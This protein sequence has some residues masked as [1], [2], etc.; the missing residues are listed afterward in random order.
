[1]GAGGAGVRNI[2]PDV[3]RYL[4]KQLDSLNLHG[5]AQVLR[6]LADQGDRMQKEAQDRNRNTQRGP[7]SIDPVY[8]SVDVETTGLIPGRHAVIE[9]AAMPVCED[10][11]SPKKYFDRLVMPFMGAEIDPKAMAIHQIP[12][13]MIEASQPPGRL[14]QDFAFWVSSLG[15]DET[16]KQK[17]FIGSNAAFDWSFVTWYFGRYGIENPFHYR[18]VDIETIAVGRWGIPPG[19]SSRKTRE[20]LYLPEEKTAHRALADAIA[21]AKLFKLIMNQIGKETP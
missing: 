17:I 20:I 5:T 15:A 9:I 11:E 10:L 12:E 3:I 4:E 2:D 21:Q 7:A 1:M 8:V 19:S 6:S 13:K 18:P 16:P 14:F